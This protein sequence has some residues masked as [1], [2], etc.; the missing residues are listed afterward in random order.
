MRE[1]ADFVLPC[2]FAAV[3]ALGLAIAIAA[4]LNRSGRLAVPTARSSHSRPTPAGPG[5]AVPAAVLASLALLEP[6]ILLPVASIGALALIGF[7]DDLID[8]PAGL[9]LGLQTLLALCA[10]ASAGIPAW[11]LAPAVLITVATINGIN[12][13]DGIN[14][15]TGSHGVL[16]GLLLGFA[17]YHAGSEAWLAIGVVLAAA[18]LGYLPHNFPV[19][20]SFP[21]DSLP[22]FLAGMY[23]IGILHLST[24]KPIVLLGLAALIP[25]AFDTGTTVLR[26]AREGHRLTEAH[27]DHA[28][29]RFARRTSHATSSATFFTL[30]AS[31][32]L[33]VV[34][35]A[36]AGWPAAAIVLAMASACTVGVLVAI[37]KDE[38]AV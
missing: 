24:D 30:S 13:M 37:P 5:I 33:S 15:I 25:T 6:D 29:Q 14:G 28:Y 4:A 10:A 19:A 35:G 31:C 3:T 12:F 11:L 23:V 36:E 7:L 9:R 20:R 2:I 21:G 1:P 26:R 17:G 27:R 32:G 16:Y 18:C 34:V 22:Y 38:V 8:L